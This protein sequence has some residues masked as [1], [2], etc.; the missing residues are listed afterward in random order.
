MGILIKHRNWLLKLI[1]DSGLSPTLF[2]RTDIKWRNAQAF[3]ISLKNTPMKFAVTN[4]PGSYYAFFWR[5]TRFDP[6]FSV[7]ETTEQCSEDS[8]LQVFKDW[9]KSIKQYLREKTEPD[10]WEQITLHTHIIEDVEIIEEENKVFTE[11]EKTNVKIS[12]QKFKAA[13]IENFNP[14]KEQLDSIDKELDYLSESVERL[15][16][17]DWRKVAIYTLITIITTLILD[18]EQAKILAELFRQ[19]FSNIPQLMP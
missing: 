12:I 14:I 9:L 15:N 19:A 8:L 2:E 17:I 10:L 16:K 18:S 5:Y 6:N 1:R 7:A 4:T 13:L 11:K 3:E